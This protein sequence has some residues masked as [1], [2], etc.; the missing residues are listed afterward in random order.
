MSEDLLKFVLPAEF[1]LARAALTPHELVY[2]YRHGWLDDEGAVR[3]AEAA[4]SIGMDLPHA[5]EEL[6]LLLR[7]ERYRVAELIRAA[8]EELSARGAA[9]RTE[10]SPRLWLY[11]A[12]DWVYE[13][14]ADFVEPLEGIEMLYAD[15][16]Y[17]AEIEGLARFMPPP[18]GE[19][20]GE[21]GIEQRWRAYLSRMAEAYSAQGSS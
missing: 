9:L 7:D 4:L 19:P 20:A 8:A 18:P 21:S 14:R 11:L 15:F 13:H 16:G 5:V 6:A 1:I 12:L 2:G 3:V 17:P 10:N